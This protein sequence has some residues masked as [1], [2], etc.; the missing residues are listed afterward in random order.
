MGS[1]G[2]PSDIQAILDN[3]A[4]FAPPV[5]H[6]QIVHHQEGVTTSASAGPT[7]GDRDDEIELPLA[8]SERARDSGV[9]PQRRLNA[10][11]KPT[12]DPATITTWQDGLRCVTKIA[13]QSAQFADS[14]RRVS[15]TFR[16]FRFIS[17]AH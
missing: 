8:P 2:S 17:R 6:G 16:D 12:I 11:S 14:I 13:T 3:L 7:I 15:L 9:R 1:S 5:Q 4:R 10:A